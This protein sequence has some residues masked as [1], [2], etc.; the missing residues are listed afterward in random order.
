MPSLM[1]QVDVIVNNS[2]S[3]GLSNAL[4][5][6]AVLGRPVVARDIP[7]NAAV[8]TDGDNGLL[9]RDAAGFQ[10]A[11]RRLQDD[12]TLAAALSRPAPERFA[13]AQ[14]LA[15][16]ETLCREILAAR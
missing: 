14:E 12:P 8:I 16:L 4:V 6:A 7:G 2:S 15:T 10:A 13:P 9:Y 11:I 1:C 5:E 3:E